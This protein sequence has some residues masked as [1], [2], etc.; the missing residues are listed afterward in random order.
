MTDWAE[1]LTTE[2]LNFQRRWGDDE[3]SP[4]LR[5]FGTL[6]LESAAVEGDW[7]TFVFRDPADN[8]RHGWRWEVLPDRLDLFRTHLHED[9]ETTDPTEPDENGV[10]WWG[11]FE[12]GTVVASWWSQ[13]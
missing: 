1:L 11:V 4:Q 12:D 6:E 3:L 13:R 5:W 7:I 8:T 2:I 9:L 10:R